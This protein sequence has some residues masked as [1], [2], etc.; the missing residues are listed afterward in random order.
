[1]P[2]K[3]DADWDGDDR[4]DEPTGA[5]EG[6]E[7]EVFPASD[8]DTPRPQDDRLA[9]KDPELDKYRRELADDLR[10]T[11]EDGSMD[12]TAFKTKT[13][14]E[15]ATRG[16]WLT[17]LYKEKEVLAQLLDKQA[18]LTQAVTDKFMSDASGSGFE[19]RQKVERFLKE[20]PTV[21]K[22]A[23]VIKAQRAKIDFITEA[24]DIMSKFGYSIRNGIDYL[25]LQFS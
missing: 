19:K 14:M 21:K 12:L 1:M 15:A 16:K 5:E 4:Q 22:M 13:F 23:D 6:D 9:L 10:L 11:H 25:K 3:F 2:L 17:Y 7:A 18:E 20:N 24:N 8:N